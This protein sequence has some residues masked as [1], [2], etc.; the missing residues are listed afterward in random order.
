M[1]YINPGYQAGILP[2]YP[3][4]TNSTFF[5]KCCEVAICDD[6]KYCSLCGREVIGSEIENELIN[7]NKGGISNGTK[8]R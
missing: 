2:L 7:A 8:G 3:F 4:G 6:Q 5:T 1:I